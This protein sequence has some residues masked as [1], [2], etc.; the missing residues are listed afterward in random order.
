MD[1]NLK[2]KNI[3]ISGATRGIGLG[4]A[5]EF[6]KEGANIAFCARN[7]AAVEETVSMLQGMG[8][9]AFG[10]TVDIA[11]H[12]KLCIWVES[13]AKKLG[14]IDV[15]IANPSAFGI[16]ATREDWE[17]GYQVDLM[18]TVRAIE[19]A[20]PHLERAVAENGDASILLMSSSLIAEADTESAYGAY[21]AALV[22]Y[23]AGLS[24]R[25]ASK[26]VR[27]N[28]ISPGT[29]FVKNGFWGNVQRSMPELYTEYLNRNPLGRM[30]TVE[31]VARAA[32]FLCS[33]MGSFVTGA[34]LF[35]DGGFTNRVNY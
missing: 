27:V 31:E 32:A 23:A 24:R 26:G 12:D 22:H 10:S 30:G 3:I 29:I 7:E 15:M 11:D 13:G 18:G 9:E 35:V 2:G 33:P 5:R 1:L 8:V 19:A 21:K 4:M 6:A 34:N 20:I 16:G 25:L 14:G 17:A 28:A